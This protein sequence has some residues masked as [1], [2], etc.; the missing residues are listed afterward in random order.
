[1]HIRKSEFLPDPDDALFSCADLEAKLRDAEVK[2]AAFR[3]FVRAND[4]ELADWWWKHMPAGTEQGMAV[5][6]HRAAVEPFM[7]EGGE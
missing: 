5:Y 7:G 3:A 1:M 2:L 6:E 4:A